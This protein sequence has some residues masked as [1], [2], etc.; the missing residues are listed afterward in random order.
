MV[1]TVQ[2]LFIEVNIFVAFFLCFFFFP[3]KFAIS[4]KYNRFI[5]SKY[6]LGERFINK[7]Y[8][9]IHTDQSSNIK[10]NN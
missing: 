4:S 6:L 2:F 5:L 7:L 3:L 1:Q 8:L 9:Q 10:M